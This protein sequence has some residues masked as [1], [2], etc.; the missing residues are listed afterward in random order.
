MTSN[1]SYHQLLQLIGAQQC[2]IV[3]LKLN[4]LELQAQLNAREQD[5]PAGSRADAGIE[6]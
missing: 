6:A 4:I 5:D 1:L 2:D 3:A